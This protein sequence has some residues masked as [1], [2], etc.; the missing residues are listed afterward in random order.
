MSAVAPRCL[1]T[2]KESITHNASRC[3]ILYCMQVL[4]I[5]PSKSQKGAPFFHLWAMWLFA[6]TQTD[7]LCTGLLEVLRWR[8]ETRIAKNQPA[9]TLLLSLH[10]HLEGSLHITCFKTLQVHALS[11]TYMYYIA[12]LSKYFLTLDKENL[13]DKSSDTSASGFDSPAGKLVNADYSKLS[14]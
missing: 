7:I 4:L 13:L 14:K 1:V 5:S 9:L 2:S 8:R 11:C 3:Q 6:I 10:R 12:S